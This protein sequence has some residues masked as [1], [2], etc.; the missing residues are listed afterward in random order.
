MNSSSPIPSPHLPSQDLE[1]L[2]DWYQPDA[3]DKAYG[4]AEYAFKSCFKLP[5][6]TGAETQGWC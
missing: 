2:S 5:D 1:E 4:A 3:N 6:F